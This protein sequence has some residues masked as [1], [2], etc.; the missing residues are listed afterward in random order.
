MPVPSTEP[1]FFHSIEKSWRQAFTIWRIVKYILGIA[2]I[3]FSTLAA[4]KPDIFK[5]IPGIYDTLPWVVAFTTGLLTFVGPT[6]KASRYRA[7][8]SLLC[9]ALVRFDHKLSD[10]TEVIKAYEDGES[11]IHQTPTKSHQYDLA[12]VH[13]GAGVT[14][15]ARSPI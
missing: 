14:P 3:F 9:V 15:P 7:A 2:A 5:I 4:A 11:I 12:M 6:E 8:W 10:V 13:D 1:E